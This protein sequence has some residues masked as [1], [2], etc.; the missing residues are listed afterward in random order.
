MPGDRLDRSRSEPSLPFDLCRASEGDHRPATVSGRDLAVGIHRSG[1]AFGGPSEA[2]PPGSHLPL[3]PRTV[4]PIPGL[5][6][7][8]CIDCRGR[9][10][11]LTWEK[12]FGLVCGHGAMA[13]DGQV[14][15]GRGSS[16]RAIG[17]DEEWLPGAPAMA[18][19]P[20]GRL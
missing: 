9:K 17:W 3:P 1:A 13:L 11:L 16:G 19:P 7:V 15:Q 20:F 18:P 5:D 8:W 4:P 14:R 10:L 12:K 6:R 2:A